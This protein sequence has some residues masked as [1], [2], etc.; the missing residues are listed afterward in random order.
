MQPIG[1]NLCGFYVCEFM[2]SEVT[3]ES[4]L[5]FREVREQ[6]IHKFLLVSSIMLSVIHNI[7][8]GEYS[9]WSPSSQ[10]E[11]LRQALEPEKR[12]APIQE[13]L[14]GFMLDQVISEDGN[15]YWR[16]LATEMA[17]Q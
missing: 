9:Y 7:F 5:S 11:Y 10:N 17:T 12:F 1:T 6:Y 14:A 8:Y 16:D 2:W 13:E 4:T 3:E 15:F